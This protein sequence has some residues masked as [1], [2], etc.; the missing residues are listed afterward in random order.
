[1][2]TDERAAIIAEME[3]KMAMINKSIEEE[4]QAQ[5]SAL[6]DALARRRA[7][8]EKLK[9]VINNLAAQKDSGIAKTGSKLEEVQKQEKADMAKIE[10]EIE[11]E[12]NL[13]AKE[14]EAYLAV[15]KSNR[16][17]SYEKKLNDFKKKSGGANEDKFADM[18]SEYGELVKKVDSDLESEKAEQY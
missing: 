8:K 2:N 14:I 17:D 11:S 5:N 13:G 9:N 18:I 10:K 4:E 6:A 16:L 7:K 3:G 12:R 1:L 15:E